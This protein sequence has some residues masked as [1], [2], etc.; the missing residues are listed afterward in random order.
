MEYGVNGNG[1]ESGQQAERVLINILNETFT[2]SHKFCLHTHY[3]EVKFPMELTFRAC[4]QLTYG[5]TV[6]MIDIHS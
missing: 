2:N 1:N 5:Q 6:A 3:C 4:I